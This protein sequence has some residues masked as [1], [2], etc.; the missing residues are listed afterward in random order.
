[1]TA[2]KNA[3]RVAVQAA[4]CANQPADEPQPLDIH[5]LYRAQSEC[6]HANSATLY[7]HQ[8]Q[9]IAARMR[10]ITAIT[11]ILIA[12]GDEDAMTLGRGMRSGLREAI[13]ELAQYTAYDLEQ[14]SEKARKGGAA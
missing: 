8:I 1:M 14:T 13:H 6:G 2:K 5:G 4:A 7:A 3:A 12:A 9:G 10:G 11:S